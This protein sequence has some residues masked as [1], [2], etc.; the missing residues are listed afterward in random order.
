MGTFLVPIGHQ[1]K[2]V[3]SSWFVDLIEIELGLIK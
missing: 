3:I 2:K 1:I